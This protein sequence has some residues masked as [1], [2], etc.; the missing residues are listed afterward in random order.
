[1][2]EEHL[3]YNAWVCG[4]R[5]WNDP[6]FSPL[7]SKEILNNATISSITITKIIKKNNINR[8]MVCREP[9]C[10]KHIIALNLANW[11]IVLIILW[12]NLTFTQPVK[13]TASSCSCSIKLYIMIWSISQNLPP[14]WLQ[15]GIMSFIRGE[16]LIQMN[17]CEWLLIKNL[18]VLHGLSVFKVI[19]LLDNIP[20]VSNS[21]MPFSLSILQ[22]LSHYSRFQ[23]TDS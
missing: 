19:M 6:F 14:Q 1:M 5:E 17:Y 16:R 8:G 20:I 23:G 12:S 13:V 21:F 11:F 22:G 7:K 3:H 9:A 2:A 4:W 10:V 18:M 15:N